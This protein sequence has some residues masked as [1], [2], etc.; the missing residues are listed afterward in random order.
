[1]QAVAAGLPQA[2][3]GGKAQ[4]AARFWASGNDIGQRHLPGET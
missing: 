1:M 3:G 4:D 2:A